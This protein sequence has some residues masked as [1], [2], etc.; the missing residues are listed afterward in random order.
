MPV[1]LDY[2]IG[3]APL[4]QF[5]DSIQISPKIITIKGPASIIKEIHEWH[6]TPMI[7]QNVKK[8]VQKELFL[9][10]TSNNSIQLSTQKVNC[11][12]PI[13][14]VTEKQIE[15]PIEVL[16]APDSLLL[17]VLPKKIKVSCSVGLSDYERL[18]PESF[19]AIINFD[20]VDIS[21]QEKVKVLLR[22]KPTYIKNTLY[23]PQ[24]VDFIVRKNL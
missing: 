14:E 9:Q 3:L 17:V 21:T 12:A 16:N 6:T 20:Q 1:I 23:S 22:Q 15:V 8:T 4:H 24:K 2:Q 18:K 5:S 13:E 19:R 7:L 11:L 10:P